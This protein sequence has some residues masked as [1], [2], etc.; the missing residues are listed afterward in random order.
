[1][2]CR[3]GTL[4]IA[5]TAAAS[6]SQARL[7]EQWG[8]RSVTSPVTHLLTNKCA[9]SWRL[10]RVLSASNPLTSSLCFAGIHA[11]AHLRPN[12]PR[13]RLLVPVQDSITCC[14]K[15]RVIILMLISPTTTTSPTAEREF[16]T[17]TF[18]VQLIE[19]AKRHDGLRAMPQQIRRQSRP[20]SEWRWIKGYQP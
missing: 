5:L 3:D 11:L 18:S 2:L 12:A 6:L 20:T 13:S 8:I 15:R 9:D 4:L 19:A 10:K 14:V 17:L 16:P 7:A 1:M